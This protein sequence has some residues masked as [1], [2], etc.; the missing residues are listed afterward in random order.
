MLKYELGKD[1]QKM[2]LQMEE[3]WS[4]GRFYSCHTHNRAEFA[5]NNGAAASDLACKGMSIAI[6]LLASAEWRPFSPT[7]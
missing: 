7:E 5:A 4:M 2:V 3:K 6:K 1:F